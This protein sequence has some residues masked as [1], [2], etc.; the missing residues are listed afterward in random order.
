MPENLSLA[1]NLS[2]DRPIHPPPS[3]ELAGKEMSAPTCLNR[4]VSPKVWGEWFT[5]E[6]ERETDRHR[7]GWRCVAMPGLHLHRGEERRSGPDV[8]IHVR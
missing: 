4:A 6:E 1:D 2:S 8:C 5:A 3:R 7:R